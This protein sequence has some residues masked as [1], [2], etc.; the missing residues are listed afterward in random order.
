MNIGAGDA[1]DEIT[2][3]IPRAR[4]GQT[5]MGQGGYSCHLLQDSVRRLGGPASITTALRR[6]IPLDTDLVVRPATVRGGGQGWI[7]AVPDE[8]DQPILEAS[9]WTPDVAS[10]EPVT[11]EAAEAARARHAMDAADHPAPHCLSC[12]LGPESLRVHAGPLD[13]GDGPLEEGAGVARYAT[14]LRIPVDPSTGEADE[15]LVW[16]AIDCACGW[17]TSRSGA[18]PGSGVTVQYA[19]EIVAPLEPETDYV[20]VAWHGDGPA[21]WDGR[22]RTS[23]AVVF[24]AAGAV[25]ARSRSLWVRPAAQN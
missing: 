5:G 9:A 19:V 21:D 1:I 3:R 22:K 13:E 11:I 20:L 6:P 25:M 23:A 15:S 16:M 17:F 4:Q 7:L 24:D 2:V 14:P 18:S 8:L 12:G 10:T